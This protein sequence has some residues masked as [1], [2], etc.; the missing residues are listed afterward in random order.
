DAARYFIAARSFHNPLEFD[1]GL[2][3]T[4]SNLN[5][6]Y[7]A[8]YAHA[9]LS[10]LLATGQDLG[11]DPSGQGLE[12]VEELTLLKHLRSFPQVLIQAAAI[13][14]PS[15]VANY[16]QQLAS[17]TH[18]FYTNRRVIDRDQPQLSRA[19]LALV[20]ASAQV[21]RNSLAIFGIEALTHM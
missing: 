18:S 3:K 9:R 20:K 6:L 17:Y 11:L 14:E 12:T 8:Q 16:L 15:M 13:R 4:K 10:S 21:I 7:Y 19:R 2:A 5:P 1:L